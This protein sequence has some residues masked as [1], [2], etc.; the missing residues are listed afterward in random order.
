MAVWSFLARFGFGM[1]NLSLLLFVSLQTRSYATA[2]LMSA[3]GLLGTAVGTVTQG[4]LVDRRG[5]T[6]PLLVLAGPHAV[7]TGVVILGVTAA[8]QPVVLALVIFAQCGTLP[9]VAV[10]SRTMWARL[11][12][13]GHDRDEAYGYEAVSFELCWLL[14]PA[15]AAVL[16]TTM[17]PGSAL[18]VAGTLTTVAAVGFAVTGAVRSANNHYPHAERALGGSTRLVHRGGIAVLLVAASGF[19]LGIGF[20][21]V[22]VTA[23]TAASGLPQLAGVLLAA[24]S[25]SS[26]LGGLAYQRRPWPHTLTLRLPALMS[27]FGLVLLIPVPLDGATALAVAAV[28]AG[29]TLIPQVTAHNTLLDGLVPSPRLAEAY[30]WVTTTV[31]AA[32]AVGQAAGGLVIDRYSHHGAF[33][34]AAVCV[35]TLALVVWIN[36]ER[37]RDAGDQL[38]P[39]DDARCA[40]ACRSTSISSGGPTEIRRRPG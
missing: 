20:V 21:V 19:G 33:L 22:G 5:L 25:I 37:V 39:A 15:A 8:M 24:W 13:P 31:T 4:R 17:W 26:I 27:A 38:L 30:G 29:L 1:T 40:S 28:L 18:L 10:A 36:R 23:G 35:L 16:A 7:L 2:G 32:N 9:A 12:P 3:A 14:G 34:A 11:T 6:R